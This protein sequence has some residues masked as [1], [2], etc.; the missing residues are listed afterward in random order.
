MAGRL[1]RPSPVLVC[2]VLAAC[3][4]F[5][6]CAGN[7]PVTRS[8]SFIIF[9]NTRPESPFRG[10]TQSLDSVISSIEN[11]RAEIII[12]TGNSVYGGTDAGGI[13]ERDVER[14]MRIFFPMIKRIPAAVYT[15]PGETDTHNGT[16]DLYVKY[17]GREPWYSF[18]YGTIH[19]IALKTDSGIDNLLGS[20]QMAWLKNDL[21]R[22]DEYSSI[23]VI[24]HHAVHV[25]KKIKGKTLLKN[26]ELMQLFIRHKVRAVFSGGDELFTSSYYGGVEYHVTGC[27]G[28]IDKR[29]NRKKF[30][31]YTVT[32]DESRVQISPERV[33]LP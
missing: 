9:G 7:R 21:G 22:S 24:T 4:M 26:R 29:E 8:V 20:E 25:E 5:A 19:F 12:H 10:F 11:R 32:I 14:Q 16:L 28:Y 33:A 30:Q 15:L 3:F 31:Y 2:A 18:N 1:T 23:F 27:G 6:G 13:I 17:S